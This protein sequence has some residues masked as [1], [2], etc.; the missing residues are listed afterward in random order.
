MGLRTEASSRYEKGLPVENAERS[1][2]RA[3]ELV[4]LIGAGKAVEG[5]VD[6]YPTKQQIG[7]VEF[8]PEKINRLLGTEISREDMVKTLEK[9][10]MKVEGDIVIPPYFRV[11]IQCLADLAEEIVR[12]Y[13]Y[14]KIDCTLINS[15]ATLGIRTK[16]QKLTDKIRQTLVN[17]GLSEICTYGFISKLDLDKVEITEDSDLRSQVITVKNPLSEDYSIMRTTTLPS[18]LQT[19]L[20]NQSK[21]NKNVGL[22]D[23]SRIYRNLDGQIEKG[24][25]PQEDTLVTIGMYGENIDF[26]ILKGLVEKILTVSSVLR[27]DVMT[28]R[29]NNSYHPGK[30]ANIKVGKN[31]IATLGEIHPLV[32]DNYGLKGEVYVAEI[33]LDKLVKYGKINKKY[34]EVAK[35]PA[36]ERDI[37]MVIDEEVEVGTIEAII[38]K[39]GR[40]NLEEIK[41]FD[42][43]RNERL[44]Q[45]KKSI[46]YSLKFRSKDRTLTDQE[47]N[48]IM[49]EIIKE[50]E[51]NL[52]AELRR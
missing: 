11:D 20:T 49:D 50:L 41:L 40:K 43:Y 22:F 33:W 13:G 39:K 26:Y 47:I 2:N 12:F 29:S 45:N 34:E 4:E 3:V 51:K 24:N 16:S 32:A 52:G 27:Y 14:D 42:V 30:T 5:K 1:I 17:K 44:G 21:K 6:V 9:L 23:I 15:E 46:A 25:V 8:N 18:M 35:F 48:N 38:Q 7:K 28:E 10:E 19:I 37:A 36:V 31:V